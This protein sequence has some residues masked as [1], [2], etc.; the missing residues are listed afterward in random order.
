MLNRI[1]I[2]AMSQNRVIGHQGRLPW[3]VPEEYAHFIRSVKGAVM[4]MG[5]RSWEVF[6]ADVQTLANV[7]ISRGH[8]VEGADGTVPNL[9]QAI[10]LAE[11]YGDRVFIAGGGQVYQEAI[12]TGLYDEIWLSTLP[13]TTE[14]DVFFPELDPEE[15]AD[16]LREDRGLY[17][18]E[19]WIH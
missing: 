5:R 12:R 7:V 8:Q 6:G 18:F 3:H 10:E 15:H 1:I 11:S 16:V 19:R 17:I 14:G 13:F 2:S 9:Q 4:I